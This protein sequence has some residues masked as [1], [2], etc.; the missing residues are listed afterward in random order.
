MHRL[1]MSARTQRSLLLGVLVLRFMCAECKVQAGTLTFGGAAAEEQE[2]WRFLGKFGYAI[3]TGRYEIRLRLHNILHED[4]VLPRPDLEIF[5]DEDWPKQGRFSAC[6][7]AEDVPAR[8]THGML[9]PGQH[10]EWGPWEVGMLYQ[11]IRPHIWYFALS[12]CPDQLARGMPGDR[13]FSYTVDYEVRWRQF[14]DSEL[15]LEM[16]YMPTATVLVLL[17]LSAMACW[18][19]ARSRALRQSLGRLHPV[20]RGLLFAVS[21]H[22]A[23]QALHLVHLLTYK[24]N[25]QGLPMADGLAEVLFMLSQVASASLLIAIAQGYT[26]I[27]SKLSEVELL[28]PVVTVITLLHVALVAMGKLQAE[29]FKYHENEGLV[30]WILL[31]ARLSLFAWFRSGIQRLRSAGGIKLQNFLQIFEIAGSAYFLAFPTIFVLVQVLAPYLQHP[32]L[33]TTLLAVQTA[34]WLWLADLFLK[35]GSYFEVSELSASILPGVKSLKPK[36]DFD[37]V[38]P[39][40]QSFSFR[41]ASHPPTFL[42]GI[43]PQQPHPSAQWQVSLHP[44]GKSALPGSSASQ[45]SHGW[46]SRY[47][48]VT[49][50]REEPAWEGSVNL[51]SKYAEEA[52][53]D[54]F[55][56]DSRIAHLED[57]H[58]QKQCSF[59]GSWQ[60]FSERGQGRHHRVLSFTASATGFFLMVQLLLAGVVLRRFFLFVDTGK[61]LSRVIVFKFFVQ[62]FPQQMCIAAYLYAWYA[63][64]GLRCQMCLFHPSHCDDQHPLHSTNLLVC[65]FTL[66]SAVANQLLLQA[67]LKPGY[68]SEDECV[69]CFFRF[70]MLSVSILP[71]STAMCMLSAIMLHL[72]SPLIYFMLGV[73]T[74]LGWGA[75]T[76]VPL[77]I[78]CDDEL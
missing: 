31:T 21:L 29:D 66:L 13:S 22:W 48:V 17:M 2:Q 68:D 28:V 46:G 5:L 43:Q 60:N 15:S 55:V 37:Y 39:K 14:D 58:Q 73:P 12:D 7:R 51:K 41:T 33:Q 57:I 76:C 44:L 59:E 30:G 75:I 34:S 56:V 77:F 54:I 53:I 35:R 26:L 69:L 9:V 23:S 27:R 36:G 11:T 67:R 65:L 16:R 49:E 10:G 6:K 3:G 25:G 70:V 18:F 61:L 4:Q 50:K 40:T 72:K 47:Q 63:E 64:N 24:K 1:I 71:F 32:I 62:D 42:L 19:V 8:K 78:C 45:L 20:V 38:I 52:R 74:V